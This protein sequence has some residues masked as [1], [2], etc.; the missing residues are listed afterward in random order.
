M[1]GRYI[2]YTHYRSCATIGYAKMYFRLLVVTW[3]IHILLI[4][5][6]RFIW[7]MYRDIYYVK[8]GDKKRTLIV[9]AGSAG[10]M[11]ARQL[12]KNSATELMPVAFIDDNVKT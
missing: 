2:F 11:V 4:G 3:M 9:G 10:T 6:S 5:G 7:R 12:L 8:K 1:Q